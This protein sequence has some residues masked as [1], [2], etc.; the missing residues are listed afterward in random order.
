MSAEETPGK[1]HRFREALLWNDPPEYFGG[2]FLAFHP[3]VPTEMLKA[4]VPPEDGRTMTM[5][6]VEH[7][8]TLIHHQLVQVSDTPALCHPHQTP[9]PSHLPLRRG[10]VGDHK[11]DEVC[12]CSRERCRL[13]SVLTSLLRHIKPLKHVL[14]RLRD[15]LLLCD[16]TLSTAQL[17]SIA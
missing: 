16:Q 9:A 13:F 15:S 17:F 8:M 3:D 14:L 12:L 10:V 2:H 1:R 6:E 5:E 7:Q 4:A 11:V